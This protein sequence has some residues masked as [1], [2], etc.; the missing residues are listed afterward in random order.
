MGELELF[1]AALAIADSAERSMYLDQA[2][3]NN[4]AMRERIEVLL[5][6]HEN[7]GSF[8]E[9]PAGPP[10]VGASPKTPDVT[11]DLASQESSESSHP[12]KEEGENM[13]ESD[14]S[15]GDGVEALDLLQPSTKPGSLGR[16]G[17][18]EVLEVLG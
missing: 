1:A 4:P 10:L 17:H 15:N 8:L 16:L 2:C 6:N 7:V 18:Y 13:T 3:S 11:Q 9:A 12:S 5:R 14:F